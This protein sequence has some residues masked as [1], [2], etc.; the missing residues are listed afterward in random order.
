MNPTSGHAE[1][2][3]VR[4]ASDEADRLLAVLRV[5]FP[6]AQVSRQPLR[7]SSMMRIS[8][9][10][11][12]VL[13][14]LNRPIDVEPALTGVLDEVRRYLALEPHSDIYDVVTHNPE[15]VS[16]THDLLTDV[17]AQCVSDLLAGPAL[18]R[19][20]MNQLG[21]ALHVARGDLG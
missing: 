21:S 7:S 10:D 3:T 2:L 6:L 11:T 19:H 14:I 15:I 5:M 9:V 17:G 13:D 20:A 18:R 12:G 16:R 4:L 1:E 8:S